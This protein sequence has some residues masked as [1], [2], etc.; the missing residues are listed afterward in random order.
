M[1]YHAAILVLGLMS[2]VPLTG[3]AEVIGHIS[4]DTASVTPAAETSRNDDR[5]II[6]RVICSPGG[7]VL[8]DCE[9]SFDDN[10]TLAEPVLQREDPLPANDAATEDEPAHRPLASKSK[11]TATSGKK[12]SAKKTKKFRKPSNKKKAAHKTVARKKA[13]NKK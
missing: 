10:E 5:R 3:T 11:S 8:P 9:R 12:K 6:Y 2:V 7:E 1:K 4:D 13:H